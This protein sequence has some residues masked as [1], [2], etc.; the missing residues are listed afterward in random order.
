MIPLP[1]EMTG[2]A[3]NSISVLDDVVHV[4]GSVFP[5]VVC[6]SSND[7]YASATDTYAVSDFTMVVDSSPRQHEPAGPARAPVEQG[8]VPPCFTVRACAEPTRRWPRCPIP[9]R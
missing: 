8:A 2:G 9:R 6:A 4:C 5:D 7:D 1:N 3:F